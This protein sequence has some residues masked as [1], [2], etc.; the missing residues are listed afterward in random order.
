MLIYEKTD[1]SDGTDV[2]MPDKSK[3][4]MLYHYW[5]FLDKS[6]SYEPYLLPQCPWP[7]NF[8]EL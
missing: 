6:F 3:E 8:T 5:Y 4:C 1:F 7:P 2:D